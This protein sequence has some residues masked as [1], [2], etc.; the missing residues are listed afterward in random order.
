MGEKM[1]GWEIAIVLIAAF[2]IGYYIS[3]LLAVIILVVYFIY[4]TKKITKDRTTFQQA[5]KNKNIEYFKSFGSTQEEREKN[6]KKIFDN[7]QATIKSSFLYSYKYGSVDYDICLTQ[8][9]NLSIMDPKE[10]EFLK[11]SFLLY[12]NNSITPE[13]F[14]YYLY[15]FVNGNGKAALDNFGLQRYYPAIARVENN[16]TAD[17]YMFENCFKDNQTVISFSQNLNDASVDSAIT[18]LM[19]L[20]QNIKES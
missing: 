10:K 15:A 2:V 9:R 14:N 8:S 7:N 19:T 1:K 13:N 4:K 12:N 18:R 20:M 17:K 3:F 6:I 11:V 16:N 5:W